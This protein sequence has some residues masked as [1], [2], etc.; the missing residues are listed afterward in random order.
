MSN[1]NSEMSLNEILR[2]RLKS[3][4]D[5][6]PPIDLT[7]FFTLSSIGA[8]ILL[9]VILGFVF[10]MLQK[11][12]LID[13]SESI[14]DQ[15]TQQLTDSIHEYNIFDLSNKERGPSLN[16]DS[17]LYKRLDEI[18]REY[19]NHHADIIKI[20]VFDRKGRVVYSTNKNDLGKISRHSTLI[21]ALEGNIGSELTE[22]LNPLAKDKTEEGQ[23]YPTDIL[24]IYLPLYDVSKAQII[25][26]YEIYKDVSMVFREAR[27]A[28]IL[29]FFIFSFGMLVLFIVLQIIIRKADAMITEKSEELRRYNR[30]LEEAQLII[31]ES[32]DEVIKHGSFHVRYHNKDLLKCWEH[33]KCNKTDCPSYQSENLRCWQVAGTFCGGKVQGY[34]AKKYGDC[35]KCDVFQHAFNNRINVIGESFN[36]MMALLENKHMELKALNEKLNRLI[37][38]DPLTQVGNRRS[39][40]KRIEQIHMMSLR[41]KRSYSIIVCDIDNFKLYND[42]YGHQQGDYAL[43]SIAKTLRDNLRKTDEVFRWGGEEFVIV[44][45]EVNLSSAIKVAENLR[46]AVESLGIEH[47]FSKPSLLT[48]SFGV[49]ASTSENV[50]HITWENV[51]KEADDGLYKAK[52]S[53]KNCV[54]PSPSRNEVGMV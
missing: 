30:E 23:V 6:R 40:Q 39:F 22:R 21:S 7:K 16:I 12:I 29:L 11:S 38:I 32:I 1:N 25:G 54:Y 2:A 43:I 37:D 41:Y 44:L 27:K 45:P 17:P 31:S 47:K 33:K 42:N 10:V 26:A 51:L 5:D 20:K 24:E 53:G 14:A 9:T 36:N 50:Q 28:G 15:F 19:M 48:M 52:A 8:F 34:F 13:Y 4:E 49:A 35:R 18:V 3:K 46:K